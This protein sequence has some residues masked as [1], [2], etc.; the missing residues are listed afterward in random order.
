MT[1]RTADSLGK[2]VTSLV[3]PHAPAI[4]C[5]REASEEHPAGREGLDWRDEHTVLA[6]TGGESYVAQD[7]DDV[8][9]FCGKI[10]KG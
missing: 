4:H 7:H 1:W 2:P 9:L 3:N 6:F 8:A 10:Q 5:V